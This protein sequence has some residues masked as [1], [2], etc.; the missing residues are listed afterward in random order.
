[1][2]TLEEHKWQIK[3]F[4]HQYWVCRPMTKQEAQAHLDNIARQTE[5]L[6]YNLERYAQVVEGNPPDE[7]DPIQPVTQKEV[8]P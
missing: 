8:I 4:D 6:Q 1:M 5:L 2:V 3:Y 7:G